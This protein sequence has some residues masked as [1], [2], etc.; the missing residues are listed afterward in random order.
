YLMKFRTFSISVCGLS[1]CGMNSS[2]SGNG[3]LD[4]VH[5]HT[6]ADNVT[7]D[8]TVN[9]IIGRS[10][11]VAWILSYFTVSGMMVCAASRWKTAT[12]TGNICQT[13]F[14]LCRVLND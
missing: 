4:K 11:S 1:S 10:R 3:E 8:P 12:Q 6:T 14:Q 13:Q 5:I 2:D 7:N 9:R